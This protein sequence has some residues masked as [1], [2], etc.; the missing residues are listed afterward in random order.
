MDLANEN[1]PSLRYMRKVLRKTIYIDEQFSED[2]F[3]RLKTL[4]HA[5]LW[6]WKVRKLRLKTT[7]M[8]TVY[9]LGSKMIGRPDRG[10]SLFV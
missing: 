8:E 2:D 7:E 9:D 3:R 5:L 4:C 1:A 6:W 10:P